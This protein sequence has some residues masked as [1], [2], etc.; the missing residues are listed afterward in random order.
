MKRIN[1]CIAPIDA[2]AFRFVQILRG[3][4][5]SP[6]FHR[7]HVALSWT[8]VGEGNWSGSIR[9][10]CEVRDLAMYCVDWLSHRLG[11]LALF[12]HQVITYELTN[13]MILCIGCRRWWERDQPRL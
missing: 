11:E 6:I 4:D 1:G 13:L 8:R 7:I 3:C 2:N 5:R 9:C 10:L 12:L